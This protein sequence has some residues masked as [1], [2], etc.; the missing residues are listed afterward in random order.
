MERERQAVRVA[1]IPVRA[2][3]RVV[4]LADAAPP[5]RLE[6]EHGGRRLGA[7]MKRSQKKPRSSTSYLKSKK[8]LRFPSRSTLTIMSWISLPRTCGERNAF[9]PRGHILGLR[10]ATR[11]IHEDPVAH[12]SSFGVRARRGRLWR[13]RGEQ[14]NRRGRHGDW[15]RQ[16]RQRGS[17][18]RRPGDGRDRAEYGRNE[19]QRN[20]RQRSGR[21]RNGWRRNRRQGWRGRFRS[22]WQGRRRRRGGRRSGRGR[23]ERR[24]RREWRR[25]GDRRVEGSVRCNRGGAARSPADCA[26][27]RIKR[28]TTTAKPPRRYR[29]GRRAAR[30]FPGSRAPSIQTVRQ[31]TCASRSR[32]G[33]AR[34]P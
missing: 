34:A 2:R 11:I 26:T 10:L 8:Q 17:G 20:G 31:R 30:A 18:Q 24:G 29:A 7:L 22:C 19:R 16:R 13:R 12:L 28:R 6:G 25:L 21:Q 3:R 27:P 9:A 15:R 32:T 33:V 5:A 14:R 1:R 4:E 23:R